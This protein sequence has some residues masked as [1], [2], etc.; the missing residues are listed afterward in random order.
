MG[1]FSALPQDAFL[2]WGWRVPFLLS[3]VLLIVGMFVRLRVAESPIF[4]EAVARED[5]QG[6]KR[7]IRCWRCCAA[8]RH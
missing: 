8:P 7:K 3:F 4:A 5:A 6:A 1:I 2:A